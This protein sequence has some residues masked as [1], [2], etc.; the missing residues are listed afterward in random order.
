MALQLGKKK[1]AIAGERWA[2]FDEDT[3]I[4]L[5][6]IDNPEYQVAL[7]RMRRRILR[8]D[9]R[10]EEGQVG[11]VAGEMTEH[12]NHAI[13]L[14][15]FIVKDW[16]GVLD[17]DGNPIKYSPAVAAELLENNIEFFVF[18][19]REGN[20]A[21]KDAA[22]ERAESVGKPSAASNGSKS[23]AGKEKSAGRSTR[24]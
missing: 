8:N 9:A 6:S 20:A 17:A 5:A 4:L 14:S 21:A 13:L 11:V 23:G 18:V 12:Q 3:K 2:K 15:H 24:G 1:P 10:F 22:E 19:L 16:E 7:E